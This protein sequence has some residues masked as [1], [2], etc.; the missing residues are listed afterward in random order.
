MLKDRNDREQPID[1][2]RNHGHLSPVWQLVETA[3]AYEI[4]YGSTADAE[5]LIDELWRTHG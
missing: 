2:Q 4:G 5:A 1:S 3:P